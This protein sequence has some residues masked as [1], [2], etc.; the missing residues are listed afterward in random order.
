MLTEHLGYTYRKNSEDMYETL[1]DRQD[2]AI[3]NSERLLEEYKARNEL[4]PEKITRLQKF[5]NW[6]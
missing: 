4:N 1:R 2:T 6:S 3:N 5:M